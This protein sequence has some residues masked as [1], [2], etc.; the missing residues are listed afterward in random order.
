MTR[1]EAVFAIPQLAWGAVGTR[2]ELS[3]LALDAR[4]GSAVESRW[5]DAGAPVPV[6][7]LVKPFL[8][9]AYGRAFSEFDCRGSANGCWRVQGHGRLGFSGALAQSCNAY[10]LNLARLVDAEAL[11]VTAAKFGLPGPAAETA[12]ARIGLGDA[13]RIAPL[14]LARAYVEL[15][16]RRGE[17]LVDEILA[18]L[19]RAARSGTAKAFGPGV[20]AKTGTAECVALRKDAGD[21]FAMALDPAEAPR[22]ALLVRVHNVPG[23][24]AAKTGARMLRDLRG[25]K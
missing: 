21:G 12:E 8:A 24:E 3:Y 15:A 18:G 13:W 14:A 7:S 23:A 4:T 19:E 1:R 10:F 25:S 5:Q 22:I 2:A 9:L 16:A 20:L 6:G 17:P 11:R